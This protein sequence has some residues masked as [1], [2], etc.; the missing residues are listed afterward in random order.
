MDF[1]TGIRGS[2]GGSESLSPMIWG[3]RKKPVLG[4]LFI[5]YRSRLIKFDTYYPYLFLERRKWDGVF[6][7]GMEYSKCYLGNSFAAFR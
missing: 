3:R 5:G 2:I 1:E 7:N 4:S 6:Q